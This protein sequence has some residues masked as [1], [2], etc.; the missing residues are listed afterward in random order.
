MKAKILLV[1]LLGLSFSCSDISVETNSLTNNELVSLLK[2]S[3]DFNRFIQERA[4]EFM[5]ITDRL[6]SLDPQSKNR[7]NTLYKKYQNQNDFLN[8]STQEEM[9]FML[10]TISRKSTL[11]LNYIIEKLTGNFSFDRE[12]LVNFINAELS[13]AF[14]DKAQNRSGKIKV[15]CE[16]V[17]LN[18]YIAA[19]NRYYYKVGMDIKTA[20]MYA[21]LAGDWAAWGCYQTLMGL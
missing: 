13:R 12:E 16:E 15:D 18:A 10:S 2:G 14:M 20:D 5:E 3:E 19:L 6:S 11:S 9:D 1:F 4:T 7:L 21:Q 17:G 8:N